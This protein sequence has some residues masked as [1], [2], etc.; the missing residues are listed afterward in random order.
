MN[1]TQI[2]R[3][4]SSEEFW[5]QET[6]GKGNVT[7][8]TLGGGRPEKKSESEVGGRDLEAVGGIPGKAESEAGGRGQREEGLRASTRQCAD[9]APNSEGSFSVVAL[10]S[11]EK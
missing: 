6:V 5:K 1:F 8:G 3:L 10:E 4:I 11:R 9:L 2:R 7:R